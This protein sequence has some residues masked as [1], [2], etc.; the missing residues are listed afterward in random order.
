MHFGTALLD[1]SVYFDRDA[2]DES[3]IFRQIILHGE[4]GVYL[5]FGLSGFILSLPILKRGFSGFN[6]KKYLMRRLVRIEPPYLIAL[7][8]F[9]LV[10]IFLNAKDTTFL[11]KSFV[12]SFFYLHNIL[13]Q[14]IPYILPIAWSLEIEVQFYLLIPFL[15]ALAL[16]FRTVF[17][18]ILFFLSLA[19]LS[20]VV[21]FSA[22]LD[23]TDYLPFFLAGVVSADIYL[24]GNIKVRYANLIFL[25]ALVSFFIMNI[26]WIAILSLLLFVVLFTSMNLEGWVRKLI[27][28][29]LIVRIGG[30]CYTLYL[31]HYPLFFFFHRYFADF[32]VIPDSYSFTF[33]IRFLVY[34][35]IS[36]G[37]MSVFFLLIEKRFM[38]LSKAIGK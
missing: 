1:E 32:L 23:L 6:L 27:T 29:D 12:A 10:H 3:S 30:M 26:E 2:I 14:K 17:T 28:H 24:S 34:F 19:I 7:L 11:L 38:R 33:L 31:L 25:I 4:K 18:R 13:F 21:D 8:V 37:I 20:F 16:Y 15:I 36:F 5:F 9:L 35:P 22:F